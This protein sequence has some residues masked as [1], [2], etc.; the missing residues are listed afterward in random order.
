MNSWF[1]PPHALQQASSLATITT[2]VAV[3]ADTTSHGQQV[4][5][6]PASPSSSRYQVVAQTLL[7]TAVTARHTDALAS[8]IASV[9]G[10]TGAEGKLAPVGDSTDLGDPGLSSDPETVKAED[11]PILGNDGGETAVDVAGAVV[12][13]LTDGAGTTRQEKSGEVLTNAVASAIAAIARQTGA[14][15]VVTIGIHTLTAMQTDGDAN[16]VTILGQTLTQGGPALVLASRTLSLGP[17][18][19]AVSGR[20]LTSTVP[21]TAVTPLDDIAGLTGFTGVSL[22]LGQATTIQGHV[23]S[24]GPNGLVINVH[25]TSHAPEETAAAVAYTTLNPAG[26]SFTAY[27]VPGT[28]DV[29]VINGVTLRKGQAA[30][31]DGH[32]ISNDGSGLIVDSFDT[33]IGVGTKVAALASTIATMSGQTFTGL[34]IPGH[35]GTLVVNGI[36][37]AP[38]ESAVILGKLI[39]NDGNDGIVVGGVT[40]NVPTKTNAASI[41]TTMISGNV[42]TMSAIDDGLKAEEIVNGITL[43]EHEVITIKGQIF[44]GVIDG[45][46]VDGS[47]T[48][49]VPPTMTATARIAAVTPSS[50]SGA[51]Q[52]STPTSSAD[53]R[54]RSIPFTFMG[55]M[56]AVWIMVALHA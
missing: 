54:M 16:E 1:D 33:F 44:S 11:E 37:M 49:R 20:A 35:A 28:N 45:V 36:I 3:H 15:A 51:S 29:Q 19:I 32:V 24:E 46:V 31:I 48:L 9:I 27:L 30:T 53:T 5:T 18:G 17:S 10:Q 12:S 23:L 52:N 2:P 34:A 22:S 13:L 55:L 40:I 26:Q 43:A 56:M 21:L 6:T 39:S 47:S 41:L 8:I 38:G 4:F 25:A 50:A 7:S 42:Y 14:T